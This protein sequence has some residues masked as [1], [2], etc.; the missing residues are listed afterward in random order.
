MTELIKNWNNSNIRIRQSDRY[1]CLSDL[2]KASDKNLTDWLR[3]KRVKVYIDQASSVTG[4]PI[5]Q[6]IEVEHGKPTFSH[7]KVAL[8]FAQWCN[9]ALEFQVD[10]WLDELLTT[11]SVT[12]KPKT[13]LELAKEQVKLLEQIEQLEAEKVLLEQENHQLAEAVDELFD[14]SSIVR[15][16]KFNNCSETNFS[17][18]KLKA[19]SLNMGLEIK[20]VPCPRFGEKNLYN[21]NV[22][23]YAYPEFRLPETTTLLIRKN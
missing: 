6:L 9:P 5:S 21:H 14:Y 1:V 7:P 11:G 18:R 22:W 19:A 8:R 12:L 3:Q 17:W 23:R 4:I 15:I 20:K 10:C 2:A 16:A 13:A